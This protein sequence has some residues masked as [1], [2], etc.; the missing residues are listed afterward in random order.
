VK[1]HTKIKILRTTGHLPCYGKT[2]NNNIFIHIN[3]Y[4]MVLLH[5][6]AKSTS[7]STNKFRVNLNHEI[8]A[9]VIKVVK[10]IVAQTYNA[11]GENPNQL[12]YMSAPFLSNF[13][14]TSTTGHPLLPISY[15]PKAFRTESDVHYKVNAETIPKAFDI[16]FFKD[17]DLTK[18]D[19][20]SSDNNKLTSVHLFIE[21]ATNQTFT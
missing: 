8:P 19:L 17:E 11:S 4:K 16:E 3:K 20:H 14:I 12:I 10:T 13:E 18:F 1:K 5:I 15:D 7:T 21:Y 9:Q 2:E 6:E